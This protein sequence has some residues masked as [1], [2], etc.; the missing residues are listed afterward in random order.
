[1]IYTV[2]TDSTERYHSVLNHLRQQDGD[3]TEAQA[4]GLV[5]RVFHGAAT[6]WVMPGTPDARERWHNLKYYTWVEQQGKTV[7]E[8]DAQRD[9]NWWLHHQSLVSEIDEKL[10]ALREKQMA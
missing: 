6:D 2:A 3:L 5:E 7:E 1:V 4:V 8:L 9:P 10:V